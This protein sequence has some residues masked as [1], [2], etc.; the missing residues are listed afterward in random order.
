MLL[1][2]RP[3]MALYSFPHPLATKQEFMHLRANFFLSIL[4]FGYTF[5]GG[6][7]AA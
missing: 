6:L 1:Y 5:V 7:Y 4:I 3:F 2:N